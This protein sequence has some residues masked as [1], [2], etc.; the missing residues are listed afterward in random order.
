M[1]TNNTQHDLIERFATYVSAYKHSM[2]YAR[3]ERSAIKRVLYGL[4]TFGCSYIF[5]NLARFKI[6]PPWG[7][8]RNRFFFGKNM[9]LPMRDLGTHVFSMYQIAQDKSEIRLTLWMLKNLRDTDIVYDVGVH[10]GYYTALAEKVATGG[11]VHAFEANKRLCHYLH[12]NFS[13]SGRVFI[14]CKAVA[15]SSGKVEFYDATDAEDSS[16]SSRFNLSKSDTKPSSIPSVSLDA[17]TRA[18]HKIPTVI[19]LD[20]EGGEYDAIVGASKLLE[21]HRP[22]VVMEVWGGEMGK[23]YSQKAVEKL[24]SLGYRAFAIESDGSISQ[25]H[26]VD[27]VA[28]ISGHSQNNPRDNFLFIKGS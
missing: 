22:R 26:I 17:Y 28:H 8:V 16:T 18:G 13:N 21:D 19:K 9:V 2:Q 4:Q 24:Q 14:T 5:Y 11:E 20:I 25:D 7:S 10:L 15:G 27:P 3:E 12:K 6:L 23:Q 1:S